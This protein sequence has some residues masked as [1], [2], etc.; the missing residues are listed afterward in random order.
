MSVVRQYLHRGYHPFGVRDP[1][2]ERP[3]H[4]DTDERSHRHNQVTYPAVL[5]R[6]QVLIS[7]TRD[8]PVGGVDQDPVLD[9]ALFMLTH[10][11]EV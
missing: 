2:P 6:R 4:G 11:T 3:D 5:S 9:R 10:R 7:F 8:S 1:D